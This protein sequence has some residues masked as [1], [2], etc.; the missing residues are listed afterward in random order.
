MLSLKMDTILLLD[1]I[2]ISR[3]SPRRLSQAFL[4]IKLATQVGG[5]R[6]GLNG[7]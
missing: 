7:A 2:F 6:N 5:N 1:G 3:S 4:N